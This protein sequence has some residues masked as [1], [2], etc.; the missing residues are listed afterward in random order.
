[1]LCRL[2]AFRH[3]GVFPEQMPHWE[4]MISRLKQRPPNIGRL[5]L[6]NLFA[7]TGVASLLAAAEGAE[8]THVDASKK[9][10]AWAKQNQTQSGL[11]TTGV[12][13]IVDDARKFVEREVRRGRSYHGVLIDPPKFGR[14]PN[15][16]VWDIFEALPGLLRSCEPLLD[17]SYAFLILTAYAIRAS[18]LSLD[19][20]VR[21][22]LAERAGHI[23]SGELAICE[24]QGGRTLSNS[25]FTRWVGED[26][27][28]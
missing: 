17:R 14:G 3:L 25:L 4:W 26:A 28:P 16:E 5:R 8:V 1:V 27:G 7:Y 13:W 18:A 11:E 23:Q 19:M 20:L 10:I 2:S 21:E 6:L 15:G 12:R 22:V 24:E 9:A